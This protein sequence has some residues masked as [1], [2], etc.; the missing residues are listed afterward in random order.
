MSFYLLKPCRGKAAF[1]AVPEYGIQLDLV[2]GKS[3]LEAHGYDVTDAGVM[4]VC[5]KENLQVS[6]YPSGKLLI[7]TKSRENALKAANGIY[8]ILGMGEGI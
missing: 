4:L 6:I 7:Q 1:E 3:D 5:T 8:A 2:R